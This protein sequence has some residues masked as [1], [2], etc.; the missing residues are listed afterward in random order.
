MEIE[1]NKQSFVTLWKK[2]EE[3]RRLFVGQYKC[4]CVRR[5]LQSWFPLS[6]TDSIGLAALKPEDFIMT[7]CERCSM[8]G[9]SL[10]PKPSRHPRQCREFI[11][12]VV[13]TYLNIG[14]RSVDIRALDAAYSEA[15]PNSTPLNISKKALL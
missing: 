11:R 12:A 2:L 5:I 10:M 6:T 9:F 7:V 13:S 4:F 15:F 3:T 14:M 1:N 8:G